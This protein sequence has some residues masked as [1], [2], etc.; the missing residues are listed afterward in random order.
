MRLSC[1]PSSRPRALVT[2]L[3]FQ[4][5]ATA[6]GS[7]ARAARFR[8]RAQ[9][10][11]HADLHAGGHARLRARPASRGSARKRC[12]GAARQ[13]LSSAAAPGPRAVRETGRHP[14]LHELAA[15]R[16]HRLG[17]LPDLLAARQPQHARGRRR[18]QK[19]CGQQHHL[20][21]PGTQHRHA[22][23]DRLGHHDG[24]RSMRAVHRRS[25]HRTA[26]HGADAPLG[27]AQPR[28]ARRFTA[29]PVRHRAGRL[30]HRS[31]HRKRERHHADALRRFRHRRPRRGRERAASAKT[32]RP[33]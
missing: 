24:A 16:A 12:A 28:C 3:H 10:G 5:E 17:R 6:A 19:L 1:A 7:R 18:V 26:R 30:L 21:E 11:S 4:L 13:Y 31:A 2:R 15:L 27:A 8:T 25:R 20:P 9:R 32:A 29:G 14:W 22:E 33:S 23:V